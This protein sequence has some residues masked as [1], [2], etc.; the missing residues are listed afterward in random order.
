MALRGFGSSSAEHRFGGGWPMA[1]TNP[2]LLVYSGK[3]TD[4]TSEVLHIR[5]GHNGCNI[6]LHPDLRL[7]TLDTLRMLFS[8]EYSFV[9]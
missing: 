6:Q 1:D 3:M 5:S 9:S 7:L 4:V 2:G 8:A